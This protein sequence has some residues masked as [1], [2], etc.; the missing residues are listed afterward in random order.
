MILTLP[1]PYASADVHGIAGWYTSEGPPP[2]ELVG[3]RL[4][5][6][7]GKAFPVTKP[8]NPNVVTMSI[9]ATGG[10]QMVPILQMPGNGHLNLHPGCIVGAV[11]LAE[12]VPVVD[13][14]PNTPTHS[15]SIIYEEVYGG[16]SLWV[17]ERRQLLTG[18]PYWGCTESI[19]DQLPWADWSPGRWAWRF[20][21]PKPTTQ[22]CPVCGG[23]VRWTPGG[24]WIDEDREP[25]SVCHG[26]GKC[27]PFPY[28]ASEGLA[29]FDPGRLR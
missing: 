26:E 8:T 16:V 25:C 15:P 4:I 22:E 5:V 23:E 19:S 18:E 12:A 27:D 10:G 9:N 6:V 7:A 29:V 2:E 17:A 28:S 21:N 1:E 11:T 3:Q 24:T 13:G 14:H 20:E